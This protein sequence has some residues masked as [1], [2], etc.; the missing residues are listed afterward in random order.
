MEPQNNFRRFFGAMLTILG[1]IVILYACVAFLSDG[2]PVLGF[3]TTKWESAVPFIVGL[4]FLLTGVNLVR[5][6]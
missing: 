2:K 1:T 4:V 6:S 3:S 5:E